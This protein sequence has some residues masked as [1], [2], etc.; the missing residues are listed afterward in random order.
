MAVWQLPKLFTRVRFPSLAPGRCNMADRGVRL[1]EEQRKKAKVRKFVKES[2]VSL[3]D[4]S[5]MLTPKSVGR[6]A[7][8]PH[9]CSGRCCGNPRRHEKGTSK[10]TMQELRKF[11]KE[12]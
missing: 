7:H 5:H 6:M 11:Q 10:Y 2:W 12:E 1:A 9:P 8:T 3:D 4:K